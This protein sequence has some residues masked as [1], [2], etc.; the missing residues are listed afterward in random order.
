MAWAW[1]RYRDTAVW[2]REEGKRR[3]DADP[4]WRFIAIVDRM[5]Y[6]AAAAFA[7]SIIALLVG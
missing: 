1:D 3:R 7:L 4:L 5:F 6:V 2:H